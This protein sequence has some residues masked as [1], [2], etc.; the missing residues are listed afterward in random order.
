MFP[1]DVSESTASAKVFHLYLLNGM[2][3]SLIHSCFVL[4]LPIL[5]GNIYRWDPKLTVIL[6][7]SETRDYFLVFISISHV[8]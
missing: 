5:K 3:I 7:T 6:E 8:L 2:F 4:L 1:Q